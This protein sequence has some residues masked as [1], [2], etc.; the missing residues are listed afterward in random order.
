MNC[1]IYAAVCK[2]F[3]VLR[4]RSCKFCNPS[5]QISQDFINRQ[6]SP[7]K[8]FIVLFSKQGGVKRIAFSPNFVF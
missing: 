2:I 6:N 3:F 1:F 4:F 8:C 7:I 5:D